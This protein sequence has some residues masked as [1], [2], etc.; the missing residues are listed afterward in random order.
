MRNSKFWDECLP[1]SIRSAVAEFIDNSPL[2]SQ[3]R[4]DK[5]YQ[6]EDALVDFIESK[7]DLIFREVDKEYQRDDLINFLEEHPFEYNQEVDTIP[8]NII[9]RA[10]DNWQ[11]KL[12]NKDSYWDSVWNSLRN[13]VDDEPS[14]KANSEKQN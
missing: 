13:A 7:R 4:G 8:I 5:Y 3:Y 14:F 11:D 6:L 12:A 10:V 1:G 9:D 2:L